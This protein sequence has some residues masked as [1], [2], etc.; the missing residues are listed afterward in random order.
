[1]AVLG[2]VCCWLIK[3]HNLSDLICLLMR[4]LLLLF[5]AADAFALVGP[6]SRRSL[7]LC[8]VPAEIKPLLEQQFGDL[9][10]LLYISADDE[11]LADRLEEEDVDAFVVRSANTVSADM[12]RRLPQCVKAIGRAG[13]GCDNIDLVACKDADLL[14]VTA[15]GANAVAV[16][17]HALG[18]MLALAR[19]MKPSIS[20]VA[21]GRWERQSLTGIG[22]RGRSLGLVGFG[23]IGAE[24]AQIASA[25]GMKVLVAPT[26]VTRSTSADTLALREQRIKEC[27]VEQVASLEE[28]FRTS[29][30]VSVHLPLTDATRSCVGKSQLQF[31]R[32]NSFLISTARGGVVN[33]SELLECLKYGGIAGAALDVFESEGPGLIKDKT[34]M[35]LVQLDS[36]LITP[37]I[38]GH[39]E[40]AQS[41]VWTTVVARL[42]E[43][44][45]DM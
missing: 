45:N 44:L 33:E 38:G 21:S 6:A 40:E 35:E 31:M 29:D 1:M 27:E 9:S 8:D 20:S 30:I 4:I 12:V 22:L 23:A 37:H 36:V 14:V 42:L 15:A 16:A 32:P 17:E 25:L 10:S 11:A 3:I 41:D 2:L 28:L 7:L 5:L 26:T 43:E 39:T 19:K 13:V 18:L 34:L 24:L